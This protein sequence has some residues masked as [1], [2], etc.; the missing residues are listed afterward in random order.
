MTHILPNNFPMSIKDLIDTTDHRPWEMPAG[1][2]KFYQ[3]WNDA[4]FLH[5][6]VD[7]DLLSELVHP[8]LEI[9]LFEGT[10]WVSLIA[11]KMEKIRPKN[12]PAIRAISNFHEI[13]L[14]TYVKYKGKSGVHFLS[15]EG[16]KKLSCKIARIISELPYCFSHISRKTG[17]LISYNNELGD[18]LKIEYSVGAT[19]ERK[20]DIDLWLTERYALFQHTKK[21]INTFEIHH[22]EWPIH[23]LNLG[24]I[25]MNYPRLNGLLL[26]LPDRKH[27]STG[28]QVISWS[29]QKNKL[30]SS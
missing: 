27:Y 8:D 24:Q 14:R 6:Q 20:E 15:I 26:E 2:W 29:K 21:H 10:P 16:G 28:V 12:F 19:I 5:W 30:V 18:S 3:E 23:S 1:P 7:F 17:S 11:F 9:D 13:N 4:I 25:E 22:I